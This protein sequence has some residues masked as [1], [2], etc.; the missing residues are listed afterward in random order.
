METK[1]TIEE[2]ENFLKTTKAKKAKL[3]CSSED[4]IEERS[5]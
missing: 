1:V 5:E 2:F 3:K 4:K